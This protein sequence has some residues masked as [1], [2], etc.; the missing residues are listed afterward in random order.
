[1]ADFGLAKILQRPDSPDNQ[2]GAILQSLKH[3]NVASLF[4]SKLLSLLHISLNC[5]SQASNCCRLRTNYH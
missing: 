1:M 3:D 4:E 5:L 2:Q